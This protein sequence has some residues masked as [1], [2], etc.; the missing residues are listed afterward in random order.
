LLLWTST[1]L[2]GGGP[3]YASPSGT[4]N[5]ACSSA[6]PCD[7]VTAIHGNGTSDPVSGQEII[8]EP[9]T[10]MVS[11][12]LQPGASGLDIHGVAGA[13]R[14]VIQGN[15]LEV[16][17]ASSLATL[18]YLDFES[19][20][21]LIGGGTLD[22]LLIRGGG[23]ISQLCQCYDG[24]LQESVIVYSGASGSAW[25]LESNGG[26]GNEALHDDTLVATQAG[27]AAALLKQDQSNPP[28]G[29][30]LAVDM[31]NVI[32]INQSGGN[33]LIASGAQVVFS[34]HNSDYANP[35]SGGGAV[36]HDNGGHVT[37]SPQFVSATDF[38]ELAS[39][40]T[41]DAGTNLIGDSQVDFDGNP[42]TFGASTDIGAYEYIPPPACQPA[43]ATTASSTPV[44]VQLSCTDAVGAPVTYSIA[45]NPADGS[46]SL[47]PTTGQATYTPAS[48]YSGSDGFGFEATSSHGT[49]AVATAT[50]AVSAPSTVTTTP[51]VTAPTPPAPVAPQ[52]SQPVLSRRTFAAAGSG[53]SAATAAVKGA[54]GTIITYT[55]SEAATTIF[56]VRQPASGVRSHGKCIKPPKHRKARGK[57][58]TFYKIVGSFRHADT[59]GPNRL[60]FTGRINRHKLTPGHYQLLSTPRNSSG[61]SGASHTSSFTIKT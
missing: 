39:S 22:R 3:R 38:H 23:S 20:P 49:S 47:D 13:P 11:A 41:V 26:T 5:N 61:Q 19:L 33:D 56:M 2:A 14:P 30:P 42:R 59:A 40:P 52:D 6:T 28:P 45:S 15:G 9:G 54:K 21:L 10:Y 35:S 16:F 46:L 55:D 25:S 24:T 34:I 60:R 12:T 43:S 27:G 4:N 50:V 53:P 32:A 7:I 8:V 36:I 17:Q 29:T 48:G 37:A 1:A 58:C 18:S 44:T 31:D 57:R 51:T